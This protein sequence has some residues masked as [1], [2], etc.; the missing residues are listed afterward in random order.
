[1]RFLSVFLA[2]FLISFPVKSQT[3]RDVAVELYTSWEEGKGLK[4]QWKSDPNAKKYEVYTRSAGGIGWDLKDTFGVNGLSYL[5]TTMKKGMVREYRVAKW[6][7]KYSGFAGNGYITAG[8]EVPQKSLGKVLIAVDSSYSI[9]LSKEISE[10]VDQLTREGWECITK[11]FLRNDSVTRIKAWVKN[12]YMSDTAGV[13]ALILLGRI[14]V[15]YSGNFRPDAHPEHT[16]AWP[17]DLYYGSFS[18]NWTDAT[19]N[20]TSAARSNNHNTPGDGKF[21]LSRY[22]TS[23]TLPN[24]AQKV[25]LPV[26]RIDLYDMASFSANDTV[27]VARYIR[28]NLAF[29]RGDFRAVNRSLI[30]DNFGYFNSEAF[31]SGGFRN[32]SVHA[33][34]SVFER[35]YVS[36]MRKSSYLWSY[37]CGS[38]YYTG[39]SGVAS[40]SDFVTDSILNPFTLTF[41]SYYGDWDNADNFLRAPLASRG[42]G[43]VSVWSGRPYWLMHTTALGQP[44]YTAVLNT[45]NSYPNYNT[46]GQYSGVHVALMGDPTLKVYPVP[47]LKRVKVVNT[48][49]LENKSQIQWKSTGADADSIRIDWLDSKNQ[50]A[51][52]KTVASTDTFCSLNFD[53]G[54]YTL[55]VRPKK[56]MSSSSGTWWD[57]GAR[58]IRS[59]IVNPL[60]TISLNYSKPFYCFGDSIK[61]SDDIRKGTPKKQWQWAV[62]NKK[63]I[64]DS[65]GRWAGTATNKGKMDVFLTVTSDSGCTNT[66]V[67]SIL[68]KSLP[69]INILGDTAGCAGANLLFKIENNGNN[70]LDTV[71]WY[72][73]S[74]MISRK[75]M[76]IYT[77][78]APGTFKL[79]VSATDNYGCVGRDT[80]E[81]IIKPTPKKPEITVIQQAKFRGDTLV[82]K[83]SAGSNQIQW[84]TSQTDLTILQQDS[85]FTAVIPDGTSSYSLYVSAKAINGGC[86]SDT[87]VRLWIFEYNSVSE[88]VSNKVHVQ[89]N[90][91]GAYRIAVTGISDV[92]SAELLSLT[93]AQIQRSTQWIHEGE[94]SYIDI[95][96]DENQSLKLLVI[97][98]R[99]GEIVAT[100]KLF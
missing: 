64:T 2:F 61:I 14:P 100:K 10:Y 71:F 79:S 13:K 6:H 62:G 83:V 81:F 99:T 92:Y 50:W 27:L 35:D 86:V 93:G 48:C 57:L 75:D 30:D 15:P 96:S 65:T 17:A 52:Y 38:G 78:T 85:I 8:Y 22:N 87:A 28:K 45:Y 60:P 44:M 95:L 19:I 67:D 74:T 77:L 43:L 3:A 53:T 7:T 98:N 36:S 41:G 23:A 68:V 58:E 55:S 39:A 63:L 5:D 73:G 12:Q 76:F 51:H 49:S 18:I 84:I 54:R 69:N 31:A 25:E 46:A 1:M 11:S 26:G 24:A 59:F 16:G 20:N 94:N 88:L 97:R 9:A 70:R 47:A 89:T 80:Q 42:W 56:L 90:Q 33:A 34:D 91:F 40:S 82:L 4:L 21:D 72:L 29:R 32:F 37:G 66:F